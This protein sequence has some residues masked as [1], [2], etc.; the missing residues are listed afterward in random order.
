MVLQDLFLGPL[1]FL[2]IAVIGV[3]Y[4]NSFT[5]KVDGKYFFQG[6]MFK[7]IGA[8]GVY[9]IYFSYY[10]TGDTIYYFRRA[11]I[12][13][14]EL[15]KNIITGFK[16]LFQNPNIYDIETNHLFAR[17]SA[18]DTSSYMVAKVCAVT[19]IICFD[20]YLA[21]ALL[22]ASLSY[23][24]IWRMYKVFSDIFPKNKK[25]IAYACLFMP[26]VFFWGSG[27]LKDCI[28]LG[29]I[30]LLV[31]SIYYTLIKPKSLPL[32]ILLIIVSMYIVGTLK[33]YV[34][35]ALVPSLTTWV[36][37][38]Y[39]NTIQ[40]SF[41]RGIS[42]PLFLLLITIMGAFSLQ[43]LST[44]F[45]KFNLE[46]IQSRA[47]DMQ[48]WHLYSVE[49]LNDGQGSAYSLGEISFT[50]LG[51]LQK[52]PAAFNVA[53]FRPYLW[54]VSSPVMLLSFLE[55]TALLLL[56]LRLFVL[57]LRKPGKFFSFINQ[58]ASLLFMLVFS[59]IFAFSVGF[60]SYNFGALS[61]YRIP[62]LPFYLLSILIL[63]QALQT[64][65]TSKK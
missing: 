5:D 15:F 32:N 54:E 49:V 48:R 3:R 63:S 34:L 12:I 26:S 1:Y 35:L 41:L 29:F 6:L 22:F 11:R 42:T 40:T 51:L 62:L 16:L 2:I 59:I 61:R 13:T 38:E 56:T 60:T 55:S 33:S 30:G 31:S 46:N 44:S 65:P 64:N 52:L 7:C 28:T 57:A 20:S 50:P 17:L 43:F 18:F 10:K 27:V 45:Q 37:M 4:K 36:F 14:H 19:N 21:N 58:H 53:I 8:L 25:E 39:R 9:L 24:G 47:E 23:I